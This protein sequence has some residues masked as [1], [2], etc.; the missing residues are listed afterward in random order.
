MKR[1]I[2]YLLTLALIVTT[3]PIEWEH[4]NYIYKQIV[5]KESVN[6]FEEEAIK[7]IIKK[8]VHYDNYYFFS[9]GYVIKGGQKITVTFGCLNFVT[10]RFKNIKNILL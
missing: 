5:L 2:C 10:L 1:I 9:L 4:E 7:M 8:S 6:V 3:N